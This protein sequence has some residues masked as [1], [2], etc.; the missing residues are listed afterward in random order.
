MTLPSNVHAAECQFPLQA[1]F[2][3]S[4]QTPG[5]EIVYR[6]CGLVM[7]PPGISFAP[8][9]NTFAW[10]WLAQTI[11]LTL[12][13]MTPLSWQAPASVSGAVPMTL[14]PARLFSGTEMIEM[15]GGA[16]PDVWL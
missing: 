15:N 3:G 14:V 1:G 4:L 8:M 16:E 11:L 12:P 2:P 7:L 13:R 6:N 9:S 10:S 5:S